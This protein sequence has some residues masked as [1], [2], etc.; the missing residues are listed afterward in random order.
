[1]HWHLFPVPC[2]SNVVHQRPWHCPTLSRLD[3]LHALATGKVNIDAYQEN[4]PDKAEQEGHYYSD[5]APGTV[6]LAL[7]AFA[8]AAGFLSVVGILLDS[9]TGWL[10]SSWVACA[11]CIGVIAALGGGTLFAWLSKQV[12][13]K[14]ALITTLALFLGAAP[15]PYATMMFSHALVVGLLAIAL[16]TIWRQTE[17]P[18]NVAS[19]VFLESQPSAPLQPLSTPHWE[20]KA[21]EKSARCSFPFRNRWD[22]LA[23]HVCGW[24]L[25]SEYT[26]GIVVIGIFVWLMST[27]WRRAIPFCIAAVPPLLLIPAYSWLCFGQPFILP[28]SLQASFP[29]MKEGLYAIK[30]PSAETAFNLI[31]SP[32]RALFWTPF[33]LMA[34]SRLLEASH[35]FA[36]I[37]LAHLCCASGSDYCHFWP[38]LGL[39]GGPTLG[40]RFLAPILPLLA[41]PCALGCSDSPSLAYCWRVTRLRSPH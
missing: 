10:F 27:D 40:P 1:M 20:R 31:F 15:L 5:K 16:W 2:R 3:L 30:W 34:G 22:L 28:Y 33:L 36:S 23:G 8:V 39:A 41:L 17:Q 18:V 29:P 4:T 35:E 13:A 32:T 19:A 26:A 9:K 11:G 25:A 7:P 37:I 12:P 21:S 6:A 38:H 24:A 14:Y